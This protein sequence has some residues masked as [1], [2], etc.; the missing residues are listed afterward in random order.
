M[1][2]ITLDQARDHVKAD[3]DDDDLL[4]IYCNAA[5]AMCERLANRNL[6]ATAAEH[7]SAVAGVPAAMTAAYTEYDAAIATANEQD[8]DR[9]TVMM[10]ANAQAKL[11]AATSRAEAIIHGLCLDDPNG[12]GQ[13]IIGAVLLAVGHLYKT[14]ASVATGQGASAVEVPLTTRNIMEEHRWT[15]K[16]F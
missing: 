9:M 13:D 12:K 11:T 15:G 1:K 16:E 10:T 2:L 5:E 14:R 4:E 8:D 7:A 3:G 6:Y